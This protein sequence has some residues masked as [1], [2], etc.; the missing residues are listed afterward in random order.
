VIRVVAAVVVTV[1]CWSIA[2]H[3]SDQRYWITD[4]GVYQKYGDAIAKGSVPYRDFELEYPPAA[5]PVFALPSIGHGGDRPA[6]DRW[7]DREMAFCWCLVTV[8]VALLSRGPVPIALVA[9]TP[10]LLG[11]VILSRFDAWPAALALLALAAFVRRR[12]TIAAVLLGVA[13]AAKLWPAVILPLAVIQLGRRRGAAFAGGVVAVVATIF[14]PFA[15]IAPGG[16]WHSLHRQAVRPLQIESLSSAVLIAVHYMFGLRVGIES[17]FG[18]QN[19]LSPAAHPAALATT[20]LLLLALIFVWWRARDLVVGA[21]A[22][23]TAFVAF[24]KVFSPQFM[25]WIA[26][27]AAVVP[28]VATWILLVAA[29]LL[30]QTWFPRH[31][32]RLSRG[33]YER[34]SLEVLVRDLVVVALF[35]VTAWRS[36]MVQAQLPGR[37]SPTR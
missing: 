27:F 35:V 18:S 13:I 24:G 3:T 30:T 17:T 32:W 22:A 11:P 31:Y 5:L 37:R 2:H 33:L 7:F 15:V 19:I 16:V 4:T 21:A 26:P 1:A 23:V 29:L 25:V 20:V 8:G 9:A 6:Y 28:D 14:L 34:E 12:L 36:R 10:V